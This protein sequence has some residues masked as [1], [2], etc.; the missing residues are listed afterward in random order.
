MHC[1]A[2]KKKSTKSV[3]TKRLLMFVIFFSCWEETSRDSTFKIHET[4]VVSVCTQAVLAQG[5]PNNIFCNVFKDTQ[6]KTHYKAPW[7]Q[8]QA[9][10]YPNS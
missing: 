8:P 6:T 7:H 9:I 3:C 5:I 1:T 2:G 10:S 4:A